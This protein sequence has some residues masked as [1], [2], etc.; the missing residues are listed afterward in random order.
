MNWELEI[1]L[2]SLVYFTDSQGIETIDFHKNSWSQT[3]EVDR[4]KLGNEVA[5]TSEVFK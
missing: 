5:K 2:V 1:L 4:A 3:S